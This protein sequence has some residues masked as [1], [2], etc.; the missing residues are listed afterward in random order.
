MTYCKL[1]VSAAAAVYQHT[2][3][4]VVDNVQFNVFRYE[5]LEAFVI[6]FA[7]TNEIWD[8]RRH[9]L[10][11]RERLPGFRGRVHRGWL[12]DW[13]KAQATCLGAFNEGMR[14]NDTMIIC[15]HSYGGALANLAAVFFAMKVPKNQIRLYTY[16]CPRVGCESFAKTMDGLLSHHYRYTVKRDPV[17]YLPLGI[18]YKHAGTH[19]LLP[20]AP[21]P[22]SVQ[23]YKE[24]IR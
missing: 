20:H 11:R 15:G 5:P 1:A 13:R 3:Q 21:N 4:Y 22:H 17:P 6:A 18:R 16:G 14:H 12:A 19:V 24:A 8:W 7:G 10:V 9:L 23:N 2:P